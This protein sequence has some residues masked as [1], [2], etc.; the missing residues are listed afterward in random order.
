MNKWIRELRITHY[1]KNSLIFLPA[2]F[3]ERLTMW[4][5]WRNLLVGFV[6]FCLAASAVY[7][8][9]DIKDAEKDRQHPKKCTRPIAAGEITIR[10]ACAAIIVLLALC[11]VVLWFGVERPIRVQAILVFAVYLIN[12]L[13]YSVFGMKKVPLLDV[14]LLVLGFYLRVLMG[15]VL[16]QIE[17]STW[18]YLVVVTGAFYLAFGK[19]RNELKV[20][21]NDGRDVLAGYTEQFLDKAM[22][23][24]MTMANI[25][26]ALWCTQDEKEKKFIVL[27]PVLLLI[28]FKYSMDIE[29]DESDGDPMNVILHD[30]V[31]IG[32][33]VVFVILIFALL[34][35]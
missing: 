17:I 12:N 31:L 11:A 29:Q 6:C 25:F 27:I 26:F 15:A 24:C 35:F 1:L 7:L 22:Y 32:L 20:V 28:C 23:S 18:L 33:G 3:G 10:Q 13:F 5:M 8:M 19:R 34:Y 21:G 9:N 30:K 14:A 16:V 2:F 4:E